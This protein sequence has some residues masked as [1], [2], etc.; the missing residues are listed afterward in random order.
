MARSGSKIVSVFWVLDE[1]FWCDKSVKGWSY[2]Y[3]RGIGQC[4]QFKSFY[5]LRL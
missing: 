4:G 1:E 5:V 2:V 3:G